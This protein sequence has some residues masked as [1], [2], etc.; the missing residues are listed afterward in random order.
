M[1]AGI[2]QNSEAEIEGLVPSGLCVQIAPPAP[3]SSVQ[4]D[5]IPRCNLQSEKGNEGNGFASFLLPHEYHNH[6]YDH[7]HRN[8]SDR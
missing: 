5:V 7:Y 8:D 2:Y 1:I 6:S 4:L 3:H